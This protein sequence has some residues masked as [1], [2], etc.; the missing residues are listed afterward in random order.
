MTRRSTTCCVVIVMLIVQSMICCVFIVMLIEQYDQAINDLSE[1]LEIQQSILAA[2]DRCLAET[3]YQLGLAC[4]FDKRYDDAIKHYRSAIEVLENKIA[5]LRRVI[6]GETVAD[7]TVVAAG[8]FES[9]AELAQKEIDELLSILP[10]LVAKVRAVV[11]GIKVLLNIYLLCNKRT[12]CCEI[13]ESFVFRLA[14]I[15]VW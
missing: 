9:P 12:V 3:L 5:Q 10:D 4:T 13:K 8:S 7:P 6:R 14:L 1:C 15:P 11:S 2:D